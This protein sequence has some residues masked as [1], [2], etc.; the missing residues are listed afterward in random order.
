MGVVAKPEYNGLYGILLG[1][2]AYSLSP[3]SLP[4]SIPVTF[5]TSV[6][7]V[8]LRVNVCPNVIALA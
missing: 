1:Q 2:V 7:V 5:F 6:S 3:L 8:V 4:P